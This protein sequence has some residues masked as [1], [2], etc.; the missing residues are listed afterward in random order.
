MRRIF[1]AA[2]F[3]LAA[4]TAAYAQDPAPKPTPGTALP[5]TGR[6]EQAT[7][8]MKAPDGQQMHPPTG[9]V[10]EVIPP[11]KSTDKPGPGAGKTT[12]GGAMLSASEEWVGRPV[13]SS[14]GKEL[15][16]VA[17]FEQGGT[18]LVGIGGFLGLGEK[19][20]RIGPDKIQSVTADQ[21]TLSISEAEAKSLPA[22]EEPKPIEQ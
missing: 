22:A 15:G 9:R 17:A 20:T 5:P 14:D 3:A 4:G 1:C 8:A 12:G 7:P 11:E 21:I 18:I 6:M 2:L 19:S 10:G 13:L 16:K